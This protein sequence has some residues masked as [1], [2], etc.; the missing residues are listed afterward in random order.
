MAQGKKGEG[1]QSTADDS[2]R[3]NS[4]S[5][6]ENSELVQ[7]AAV[8][9]KQIDLLSSMLAQKEVDMK[10]LKIEQEEAFKRK[11]QEL[12]SQLQ[13]KEIEN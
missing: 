2:Q 9:D 1:E 8:K 5:M 6:M 12:Q 3:K 7:V 4:M 10:N 13:S 11:E